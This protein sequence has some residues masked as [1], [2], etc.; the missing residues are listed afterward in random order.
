MLG[1][2]IWCTGQLAV[3]PIVQ[4]IGIAKGLII[5]GS[6]AMLTGWACSVFGLLGVTSQAAGVQSWALNLSG[7]ALALASLS[8]SL[9]LRPLG[10]EGGGERERRGECPLEQILLN[11]KQGTP[12]DEPRHNLNQDTPMELAKRETCVWLAPRD[13]VQ[14]RGACL[15]LVAGLFFGTNFNPSQYIIDRAGS[16]PWLDASVHGLDY[17]HAQF[18][19]IL[20]A[21]T[22]YFVVYAALH[23]PP[24]ILPE[25]ALPAIMSGIMWGVAD[26]LW[27]I[28]NEKLGFVVAFPIILA[29]PGIVASSWSIFYLGELRG[30]RN[31]ML[32]ALISVL[33]VAGAM[34]LSLSRVD[35]NT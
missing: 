16:P 24:T 10:R 1:G 25:V 31:F 9:L 13:N 21:S 26:S 6:T 11:S 28:A 33:V 8:V 30:S 15:A 2:A 35:Y 4:N 27:F 3:V 17:V 7:L 12:M 32:V 14:G 34:L 29:G 5:W 23:R 19:G 20:L 18:S 22:I